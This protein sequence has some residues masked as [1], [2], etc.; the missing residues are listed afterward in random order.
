MSEESGPRRLRPHPHLRPPGPG[1]RP[2][3]RCPTSSGLPSTSRPT[4]A[5][6]PPTGRRGGW[7][8][9]SPRTRPGTAGNA[10]RPG[11]RSSSCSQVGVD[12]VQELDGARPVVELR[13]GEAMVNPA[14]RV[15]HRPGP[16]AG[17]GALHHPRRRH[18]A[19]RR[20]PECCLSGQAPGRAGPGAGTP[21][22]R[23]IA[24]PHG[25]SRP[26][27]S[28]NESPRASTMTPHWASVATST[29]SRSARP[30]AVNAP[31]ATRPRSD[32]RALR[33]IELLGRPG[34]GPDVAPHRE[35][36]V[37]L[38]SSPIS[39]A[40]RPADVQ[41]AVWASPRYSRSRSAS[42]HMSPIG[43]PGS[44]RLRSPAKSGLPSGRSGRRRR[45]QQLGGALQT[46]RFGAQ[47][48]HQLAR[49][50]PAV[51]A[52]A[53]GGRV[54]LGPAELDRGH[55]RVG[56]EDRERGGDHL[57]GHLTHHRATAREVGRPVGELHAAGE[58]PRAGREAELRV[59][60]VALGG[61]VHLAG[62][63]LQ[64]HGQ[65]SCRGTAQLGHVC[66]PR[67]GRSL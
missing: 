26:S 59:G 31:S 48:P 40:S 49:P 53:D 9:S 44:P 38:G 58:R 41:A 66:H 27:N 13:P 34:T 39:A 46:G 8:A 35:A 5:G 36:P 43:S 30:S 22:R 33:R 63:G 57:A 3:P 47:D 52:R 67:P 60:R 51:R 12:I 55:H 56:V 10:T 15:A 50:H 20:S 61:E 19:P 64:R 37:E 45:G 32:S 23:R 11:K 21:R 65:L 62:H 24:W 2:R 6:S 7:S 16:R 29:D 4:A 18:G 1:F 25:V 14:E 54:H 28:S 42:R 17:S